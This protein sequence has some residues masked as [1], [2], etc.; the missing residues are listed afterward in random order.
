MAVT[1]VWQLSSD[2]RERYRMQHIEIAAVSI[3]FMMAANAQQLG[4]GNVFHDA[5]HLGE[6]QGLGVGRGR[7]AIRHATS[8]ADGA[9]RVP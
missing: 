7:Q 3:L 6:D 9:S 1:I 4:T 2:G 8:A 5:D